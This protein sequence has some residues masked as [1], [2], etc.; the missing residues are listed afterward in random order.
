[1]L[2]GSINIKNNESKH[3]GYHSSLPTILLILGVSVIGSNAFLMSPILNNISISIDASITHV[4]WAVSAYGGA[5]ALSGILLT[6]LVQRMGSRP[7]LLIFGATLSAGILVTGLATHWI[8]LICAQILAGVAAG[9]ILPILYS[10]TTVIAQ[11]GKESAT[12]GKVIS[13]WSLAMVAGVPLSAFI[14][15]IASWRYAYYLIFLFSLIVNAGYFI[16][17]SIKPSKSVTTLGA[18]L[19]IPKAKPVLII[20]L[21][22]MV[23]FYGVYIFLGSYIQQELDYSAAYAG[24]A[25]LAYGFGFG[26]A[27][28]LLGK[29]LDI[30]TPWKVI[31]PVLLCI[32]GVYFGFLW[33]SINY[34][35]LLI[36]CVFWGVFNQIGLNCLVS[37][38]TQLDD[39]QRIRL[40]GIYSA[41]SYG[42]TMVAGLSFG[43][44][45]QIGG[46]NFLLI[47]SASLCLFAFIV[48]VWVNGTESD[49]ISDN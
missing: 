28:V 2:K 15:D 3:G 7:A 41:V 45:Y 10:M 38:L 18:A 4:A 16:L 31:G 43:V 47:S 14:S 22:Y 34:W 46:F 1:M 6:G 37:I 42:G 19:R 44:L 29:L 35:S 48:N 36:G 39:I 40:M 8:F 21:L 23:S 27:G 17:P 13:G 5:T 30:W 11:K 49:N 25:V 26:L 33:L 12:L 32:C 24:A 20:S 9:V